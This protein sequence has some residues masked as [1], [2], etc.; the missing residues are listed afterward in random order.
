MSDEFISA[1][2]DQSL[3]PPFL[4][5]ISGTVEDFNKLEEFKADYLEGMIMI[6]SS[7]TVKHERC[8]MDIATAMAAHAKRTGAG[9][10]LG[11]RL[12]AMLD[13]DKRFEPDI[14][15]V[16]KRNIGKFTEHEF[17]GVPDL[18]VEIMSETTRKYDLTVKRDAYKAAYVPEIV[19][20]DLDAEE[21][22]IDIL[23]DG[24]YTTMVAAEGDAVE[25]S[26]LDG[27][28]WHTNLYNK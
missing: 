9:E 1:F 15:F 27:F 12:I 22:F 23:K 24:E 17:M 14:F 16:S 2:S 26:V 19:F 18:I 6:Q 25:S 20:V 28:H 13:K 8:F 11:S 3:K 4:L 10:A 21:I 5:Y 7:A